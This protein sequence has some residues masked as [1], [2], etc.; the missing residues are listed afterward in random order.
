MLLVLLAAAFLV[1]LLLLVLAV[2]RPWSAKKVA[3]VQGS[4]TVKVAQ[5]SSTAEGDREL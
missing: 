2:W 1:V 3:A 5:M 4:D